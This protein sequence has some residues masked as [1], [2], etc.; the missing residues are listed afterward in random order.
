MK[1]HWVSENSAANHR[2][3]ETKLHTFGA[4][5][6]HGLDIAI[7][8]DGKIEPELV[9]Q[10]RRFADLVPFGRTLCHL[11]LRATMNDDGGWI[12]F[13]HVSDP[14]FSSD[15]LESDARFDGD[16]EMGGLL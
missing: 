4:G 10:A 9:A 13:E 6:F 11:L 7:S 14:V 12:G 3:I 1:I 8:E 2:S 5:F 15:F 16:G